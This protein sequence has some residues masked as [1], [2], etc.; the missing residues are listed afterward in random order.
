MSGL[1]F[2]RDSDDDSKVT[3]QDCLKGAERIG[4]ADTEGLLPPE[5]DDLDDLPF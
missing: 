5:P 2:L 4:T 1:F 3:C